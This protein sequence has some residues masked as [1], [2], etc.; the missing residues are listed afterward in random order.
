MF[1][2][3]VIS[4]EQ[5][6]DSDEQNNT[7]NSVE[8]RNCL[9]CKNTITNPIFAPYCSLGCAKSGTQKRY[10]LL[11]NFINFESKYIN[12]PKKPDKPQSTVV[13]GDKTEDN[14]KKDSKKQKK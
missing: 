14:E 5:K 6:G 1:N 13:K 3:V 9:Y 8:V 2:D 11:R 12:P 10:A 4:M 7:S